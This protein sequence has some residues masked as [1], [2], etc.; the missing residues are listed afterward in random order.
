[1]KY[2]LQESGSTGISLWTLLNP[3]LGKLF[4]VILIAVLLQ[5]TNPF[6]IAVFTK[7]GIANPKQPYAYYGTLLATFTS[8]GGI[9]IGFYYAA[10]SAVCGAIYAKVPNNMRDL[11]AKEPLGN[12]YMRFLAVLTFFGVCLLTFHALGF[13]PVLLATLSLPIG[14]GL[15]IIGFVRLGMRAFHLFDPTT[16][17]HSIFKDLRQLYLQMQASGHRWSDQSFQN[18]AH[19]VAQ[20]SLDALTTVSD[21]TAK[22]AHLKGRPFADLCNTLLSFLCSYETAKKSIPTTSLWYEKRYE[23]SDWYRTGDTETSVAHLTADVPPPQRISQPRWIESAILPIVYCC[24]TINIEEKRYSIVNSILG[25]LDAYCQQLAEEQQ[26]ESAFELIGSLFSQCKSLLFVE[27]YSVLMEEPLE[28]LGICEQLGLIPINVLLAYTRAI[29]SCG[30]DVAIQRI[31]RIS[32]KSEKSIYIAGFGA[33]VLERLEWLRPRLRFEEKV[34][35]RVLCPLSYLQELITQKEAENH[36]AAMLCFFEN[37]CKLYEDWIKTEGSS[38]HPWLVAVMISRET[39]YWSKLDYHKASLNQLWSDLGSHRSIEGLPW[40]SLN[41]D[42]LEKNK[43]RRENELLKLMA[44]HNVLL[45]RISRKESYPDYAGKFLHTIGEALFN[46]MY[47][48]ECDTVD[49]I[50]KHFL[51]GSLLQFEHLRPQEDDS[52]QQL[53]VSL[54]VAVAPLLDLIDISGYA[55]L[56]SDYHQTPRLRDL[57]VHAWDE[58]LDEDAVQPRLALLAGAVGLTESAL[59]I[60]H[61]GTIRTTWKQ[62]IRQRLQNLERRELSIEDGFYSGIETLVMHPSPLVRIFA[63]DDFSSLYDGIDIFI[64][65]YVRQKEGGQNLDFGRGPYRD[66]QDAITSEEN[67]YSDFEQT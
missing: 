30:R 37:V 62:I 6:V 41:M 10:I 17:S 29:K 7:M 33:H 13:E 9:F 48:N 2:A 53:E 64:A 8:V 61:R 21:I 38:K 51:I 42:D 59:E 52:R 60:A 45:S 1:M 54:K 5:L 12:A 67:R 31:Q 66:I 28:N 18:H 32:W 40:P 65:K 19:G 11:L 27:R 47:K 36:H 46:A 44:Q 56:L 63:R 15:M 49:A 57:V 14:A 23:F 50:F 39:E 16:L 58:Y 3:I 43:N 34:E 35:G 20:I 25:Y 4:L 24:L 55:Y 26:I 22:E